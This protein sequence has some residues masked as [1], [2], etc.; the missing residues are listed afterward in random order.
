ML[1]LCE[2]YSVTQTVMVPTMIGMMLGHPE[3]RPE[4]LASLHTLTYG[5]SPMPAP[6]LDG[7]LALFPRSTCSRVTA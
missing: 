5:A 1:E 6:L 4:R 2:Q 3:F 7:L